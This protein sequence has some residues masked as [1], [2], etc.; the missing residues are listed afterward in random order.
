MDIDTARELWD[1]DTT[2]LNTAQ[3]G[4]PPRPAQAALDAAL[5]DWQRG[6]PDPAGWSATAEAA[7]ARFAEL[8]GSETTDVAQ[9]ASTAQLL[10]TVA[11][12]APDGARILVPEEDYA[13]TVF[14]WMAQATRGVEVRPVPLEELAGAIDADTWLVAFSI[15]QSATGEVAPCGEILRRA[16]HHGCLVVGD[17]TQALGWLPVDATDYDALVCSAYKWLM[18]PRGLAYGYFSPRIRPLLRAVNAGPGAAADPMASLYTSDMR[19]A[20]AAS[21]FDLSPNWF[22]GVVAAESMR[23]LLEVGVDRVHAHNT[24]VANRFLEVLG[25]TPRDSAIVTVDAPDGARRLQEAGVAA[26]ERGGRTRL[27]FHLYSTTADAERA[28]KALV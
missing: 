18:A 10:G 23:V 21:R 12:S 25:L 6:S 19:L 27:A 14:P 3:V 1:L 20:Q 13:S 9:G 7:R 17:A 28:A 11:S 24:A 15:V 4:V 2:W 22:A 16:R 26:S 8:T 5:H